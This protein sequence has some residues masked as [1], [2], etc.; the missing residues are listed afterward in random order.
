MLQF[1]VGM[2]VGVYV[3]QTYSGV[4]NLQNMCSQAVQQLDK[5]KKEDKRKDE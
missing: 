1:I 2:V 5:F 3:V 4:P